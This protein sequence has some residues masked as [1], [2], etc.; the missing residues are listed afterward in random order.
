VCLRL[1]RRRRRRRQPHKTQQSDESNFVEFVTGI[2]G[3]TFTVRSETVSLN[4][5]AKIVHFLREDSS[6]NL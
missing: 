3:A 6:V 1:R 2:V 5:K 4:Y